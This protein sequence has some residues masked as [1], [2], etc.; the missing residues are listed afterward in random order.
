MDLE[1][2]ICIFGNGR[3]YLG[4]GCIGMDGRRID[5]NR[6]LRIQHGV[7][8]SLEIYSIH[9]LSLRFAS[10]RFFCPFFFPL[11]RLFC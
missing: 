2:F 4:F 6:G 1:H 7:S 8:F 5:V 10:T 9:E 11:L 3:R